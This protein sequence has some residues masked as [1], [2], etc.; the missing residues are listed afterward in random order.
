MR[1]LPR[2]DFERS[3]AFLC[4][5][6]R[7]LECRVF[8]R[9]F[10]SG[11]VEAVHAALAAYRNPDG[12]FGHALE[13]DARVAASQPLF[14]EFALRTLALADADRVEGAGVLFSFLEKATT[15]EG[16]V[17]SLFASAR[18]AARAAHWTEPDPRAS[19]AATGVIAGTLR[20][21]GLAHPWLDRATQFCVDLVR[22]GAIGEAH[23]VRGGA[24]LC[25]TLPPALAGELEPRL[26]AALRGAQW[27]ALDPPVQ[28]YALTP[29]DFAPTPDSP[30]VRWFG[31]DRIE[32]HLDDLL[33]RRAEDGG[34]PVLW[35]PPPGAALG[36]W[37]AR[38]TLEALRWLRDWGR[39]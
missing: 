13:P 6:G 7:V 1:K 5:H 29:L 39:L 26:E 3:R 16:G 2:P 18:S 32:S 34:W 36:E 9:L 35:V 4:E 38:R 17:P 37:R 23:A 12:G 20:G 15:G 30:F 31:R 10:E 27:F 21:F 22:A 8:E 28:R 19:L 24:L 33:A 14:A 25:E 11:S